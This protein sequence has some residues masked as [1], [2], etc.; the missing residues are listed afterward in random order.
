M[1]GFKTQYEVLFNLSVEQLFYENGYCKRNNTDPVFDFALLPTNGC[2]QVLKRFNMVFKRTN[3]NAGAAVL[4][5]VITNAGGERL[6]RYPV[7]QGD[8][9]S[10]W[11][12]LQNQD[13][14]NFNKLPI[15]NNTSTCYHFSNL[16]SD[17]AAPR[18]D[19]H[20]SADATGVDGLLDRVK[21]SASQYQYNSNVVVAPGTVFIKHLLTGRQLLP[22]S[23]VSQ[24][25]NSLITFNLADLPEG[26]CVLM[27][28]ALEKDRFYY[29]GTTIPNA[30]FAIIEL[31]LS[32]LIETNY[33][34]VETNGL[35]TSERPYYKV[36]FIQRKTFWR[37]T[38]ALQKNNLLYTDLMAMNDADRL[39]FID[40]FKMVC[41]DPNISFTQTAANDGV[42]EF[43]SDN[44]ISLQ[45]KYRTPALAGTQ[46]SLR[47][48]VGPGPGTIVKDYLPFPAASAL[49]ATN[50][51]VL[52]SDIFLT[53]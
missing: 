35:L 30:L 17:P 32:G 22:L 27:I 24:S 26:M 12:I 40:H 33:R 46:I 15:T 6:L 21:T 19:L 48:N 10:F 2:L 50:D 36:H 28:N 34:L 25:G 3:Q 43:V 45:E 37:Y 29:L 18:N 4:A 5:E 8:K 14:L 23:I 13:S 44:E 49:D 16:V 11:M 51:P 9:L 1:S 52:Y 53:L 31:S 39:A 7:R 41:N 47:K 38:I 20:L 42:F